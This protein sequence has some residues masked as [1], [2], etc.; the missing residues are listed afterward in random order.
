[1]LQLEP[2][3]FDIRVC[4]VDTLAM[5]QMPAKQKKILINSSI[6]PIVPDVIVQDKSRVRQV[7]FNLI[8]M[9]IMNA[10]LWY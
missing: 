9:F 1:M 10:W 4:L 5:F 2:V 3:A 6:D 7:L 8:G